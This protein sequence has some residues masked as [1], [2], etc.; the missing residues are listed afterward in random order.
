MQ[1]NL[2]KA[3]F[4]LALIWAPMNGQ[5]KID[6]GRQGKSINFSEA[7]AT[8][9]FQTGT[10]LPGV[11]TVG[12]AFLKS[13]GSPTKSLYT[14]AQNGTWAI[15]G[16]DG[17]PA[18]GGVGSG[19]VAGPASAVDSQMAIFS[20]TTGKVLKAYAGAGVIKVVSGVPA[21]I[22]GSP[23]DCI[24]V[25]GTSGACATGSTV[26]AGPGI[27]VA[28]SV[29]SVDTAVV[30]AF[31]VASATL[32]FGLGANSC[33]ILT[34]SFPGAVVGD[35]VIGAWPADMSLG[36]IPRILISASNTAQIQLCNV[37]SGA[38]DPPSRTYGA[39]IVRSF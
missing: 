26:T 25:N 19:D 28:G 14:C 36:I 16:D 21:V 22:T 31:L 35:S 32:D 33:Q 38:I 6:L 5:T 7:G 34:F 20:G 11:C 4:G 29:V 27:S 13:D 12:E 30:P 10:V 3:L 18:P 17:V 37:T 15:V 9:P 2:Q 39:T 8:K 1:N 23:T 24:F